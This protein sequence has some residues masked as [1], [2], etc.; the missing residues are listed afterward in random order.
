M[1]LFACPADVITKVYVSRQHANTSSTS[2]TAVRQM[3]VGILLPTLACPS[4]R[5]LDLSVLALQSRTFYSKIRLAAT[6]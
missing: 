3:T 1:Y 6:A 5:T 2:S 4:H